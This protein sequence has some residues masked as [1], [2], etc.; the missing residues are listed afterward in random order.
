MS[1]EQGHYEVGVGR[2]AVYVRVVGLATMYNAA[3][4]RDFVERMLEDGY[5]QVVFDLASCS[6]MDSTFLGVL[7]G[8]ATHGDPDRSPLV[9]VVNANAENARLLDGVG[10]TELI[11]IC[12]SPVQP[13]PIRTEALHER[14][15]EE[16]RLEL[17]RSAHERLIRI[18]PRNEAAFGA[19]VRALKAQMDSPRK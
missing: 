18:D 19:F 14:T 16:D 2:D 4:V 8:A 1:E 7:A 9:T 17:I 3:C 12:P 11:R 10:L 5:R 6:G 15:R 13:P